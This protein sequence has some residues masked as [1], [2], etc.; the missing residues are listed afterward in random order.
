ML[1][2]KHKPLTA[3]S[4]WKK[5]TVYFNVYTKLFKKFMFKNIKKRGRIYSGY[6]SVRHLKNIKNNYA[7][8]FFSAS[9]LKKT[10]GLFTSFFYLKKLKRYI[11]LLKF[12]DGSF[13]AFNVTANAF[14]GSFFFFDMINFS[15]LI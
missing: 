3:G 14:I 1:L 6:I 4:R 11:G 2:Y 9:F 8:N 7:F 13:T 5:K 12:S 15:V 10:I